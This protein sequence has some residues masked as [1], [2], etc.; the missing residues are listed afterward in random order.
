MD[1]G[2]VEY[3]LIKCVLANNGSFSETV[4]KS[5]GKIENVSGVVKVVTVIG[6]CSTCVGDGVDIIGIQPDESFYDLSKIL[7]ETN[8]Y[9]F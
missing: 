6:S 9:S 1:G 7:Y 2:T 5:Y 8:Y 4:L 3:T